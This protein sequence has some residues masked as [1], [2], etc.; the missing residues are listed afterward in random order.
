M[1]QDFLQQFIPQVHF[2]LI[3]IK[4]L[5]ANQGYQRNLSKAHIKRTSQNFDPYQINP[6]KVSRRDGIN[7]VFDGQHTIETVATASGSRDTPVWCMIYDDLTYEQEADIFANQQKF[8]KPLTPY[9]IFNANLEAGNQLQHTIKDMV[10]S[11]NLTITP[12]KAPSSICAVAALEFIYNKFGYHTLDRTL[13]LIVATWEG[14]M[15]SFSASMLKGVAKVVVTYGDMIKMDAFIARLGRVSPKEITRTAKERQ[16]GSMG[17]AEVIVMYYNKK[18]KYALPMSRL[19]RK[20]PANYEPADE[21]GDQPQESA[22]AQEPVDDL[23]S[24]GVKDLLDTDDEPDDA[25]EDY[26]ESL[27][28]DGNDEDDVD[29]DLDD[30]DM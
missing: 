25:F 2:E 5:V 11:Y 13:Y 1:E 24:L 30:E 22:E 19:Y 18:S 12:G 10:E 14:D 4:N 28:A 29:D 26:D 20:N 27:D 15:I 7:N 6:V 23:L 21:T 8:N 16:N 9:E 17:F 3:P